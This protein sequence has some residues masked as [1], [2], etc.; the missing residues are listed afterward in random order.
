MNAE[1][2]RAR[3][4]DYVDNPL[5]NFFPSILAIQLTA[6]EKEKKLRGRNGA[7]IG[8]LNK[9]EIKAITDS[10]GSPTFG[11]DLVAALKWLIIHDK[12]GLFHLGN[13]GK[14]SRFDVAAE[15]VKFFGKNIK[16]VP[17]KNNYFKL[18]ASRGTNEAMSSRLKLMRPW[19]DA[20]REYLAT[21]WKHVS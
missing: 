18:T 17:V 16:L 11:K 13:R 9:P 21:Q 20:L 14:A 4:R 1:L 7:I 15:I 5:E 6:E 19:Q 3:I 10:Y 2:I 8:Q 12:K